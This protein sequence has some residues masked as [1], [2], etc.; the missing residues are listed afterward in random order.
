MTFADSDASYESDT[1]TSE[2]NLQTYEIPQADQSHYK[3]GSSVGQKC[4]KSRFSP[5]PAG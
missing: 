1:T 5:M 4:I 3:G 2:L